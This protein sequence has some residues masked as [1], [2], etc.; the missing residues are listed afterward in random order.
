MG[1]QAD[2]IPGLKGVGPKTAHNLI[3]NEIHLQ[4]QM[5]DIVVKEYCKRMEGTVDEITDYLFETA[6]LLYLRRG[7]DDHWNPPIV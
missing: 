7:F 1:D 4:H 6:N 5:F 3:P 2:N